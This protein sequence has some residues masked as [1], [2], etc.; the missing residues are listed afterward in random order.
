M[1]KFVKMI[2]LSMVTA[3]VVAGCSGESKTDSKGTVLEPDPSGPVEINLVTPEASITPEYLEQLRKKFPNYT[4]NH[5]NQS[6]KGQSI[7]DLITTGV[8]VDILGRAG[9]G[10]YTDLIDTKLEF[11]MT[12]YVKEYGI[13]L[14]EFEP[15]I[16]NYIRTISNG[17]LYGVPGGTAINH[18]LFYNKSLFDK[19]GVSYPKD[20]MTWEQAMDLAARMTRTD[21]G[22][23]Y[24]GF[25]GHLGVMTNWNQFGL[26]LVDPKTNKPTINTDQRWKSYFQIVYGNN[27]LNEAYRRDN[28]AF[29]GSTARLTEG[30]TAMV[31][32]NANIALATK[33]LQEDIVNWDMVAL[34]TFK[35]APKTGSPMNSSIFALTKQT[36]H[37]RASMEVIKY[38]VSDENMLPLTKMG[39]LVPKITDTIVKSFATEAKPANKNWKGIMY[40][41]YASHPLPSKSSS[42]ISA[43]HTKYIEAIVKGQY[44]MNT[45]LRMAE[46][47]ALKV[48]E[49]NA[50]Q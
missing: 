16:M 27:V 1:G 49:K 10:F 36:R 30:R 35:D 45:A 18:M 37:K 22:V 32:F 15:Q 41:Q 14:N 11:D 26:S 42:E 12:P 2:T 31:L 43:I 23:N 50:N 20:G 6:A 19:F 5:I 40:N 39:Y 28:R 17:G 3:V 47:E 13:N 8:P 29:S 4:I 48:I 25:T 33:E 21:S 34:P 7:V 9:A 38:L 24:Y 46:E 44:D